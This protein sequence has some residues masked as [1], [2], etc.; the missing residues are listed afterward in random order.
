MRSLD[1]HIHFSLVVNQYKFQNQPSESFTQ[2]SFIIRKCFF[3]LQYDS[4]LP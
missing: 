2:I 4:N 1:I 3:L